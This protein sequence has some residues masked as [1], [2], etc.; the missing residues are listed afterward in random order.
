MEATKIRYELTLEDLI[1]VAP[2]DSF[3]FETICTV[4]GWAVPAQ[5]KTLDADSYV[6]QF[7]KYF[8][9][10]CHNSVLKIK[11]D[12]NFTSDDIKAKVY[13]IIYWMTATSVVHEK[14]I[15]AIDGIDDFM[16]VIESSDVTRFND[17]PQSPNPDE[18]GFTST[19]T[20]STHY[21][22]G[23]T[24]LERIQEIKNLFDN[25]LDLSLIHI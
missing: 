18:D 21:D 20:K 2:G 23:G 6:T 14:V 9:L 8:S 17:T 12:E 10:R 24:P 3:S 22:A 16:K 5:A 11:Y 13:Q 7:K 15:K 19:L 4:G 1:S 25:E